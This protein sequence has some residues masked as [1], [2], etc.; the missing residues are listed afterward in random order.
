MTD[1]TLVQISQIRPQTHTH[2]G[3][4]LSNPFPELL[5]AAK[6][7]PKVTMPS[8]FELCHKSAITGQKF[9][10]QLLNGTTS[11]DTLFH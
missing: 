11:H 9:V 8:L 3:F 5:Q 10:I 1:H 4:C 2:F 7:A 6:P